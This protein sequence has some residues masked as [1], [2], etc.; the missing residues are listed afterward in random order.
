MNAT[1][2]DAVERDVMEYDFLIVGAGPA[3][4]STAIE[5]KK[6]GIKNV[7]VVDREP[8]AGGMPRMCH[9]TGCGRADLWRMYSGPRYARYYRKIKKKKTVLG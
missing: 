5:L 3:G 8:E 4:L 2:N 9:H 6:Q 7:L 1:S